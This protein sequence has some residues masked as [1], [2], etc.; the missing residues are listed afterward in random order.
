LPGLGLGNLLQ[1][2]LTIPVLFRIGKP[3]HT[4]AYKALKHKSA[5]MDVLVSLGTNIAFFF[6][7]AALLH[8]IFVP[9]FKPTIFFETS[10][11]L[12]TFITLGRWMYVTLVLMKRENKAKGNTGTAL[13]KLLS[14]APSHA[15]LLEYDIGE[16]EIPVDFIHTGGIFSLFSNFQI[17]SK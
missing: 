7:S 3:F 6:S 9:S 8:G 12:I 16:K 10:S 14:L 5:N 13:S 4:A 17:S 2:F 1:F 15:I 11:T